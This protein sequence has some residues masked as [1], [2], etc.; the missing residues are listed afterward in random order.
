LISGR[1]ENLQINL[2]WPIEICVCACVCV[3]VCVC[4]PFVAS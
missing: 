1:D 2:I 4:V 3:C